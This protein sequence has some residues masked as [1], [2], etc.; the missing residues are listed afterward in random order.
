[1][2]RCPCCQG[3]TPQQLLLSTLFSHPCFHVPTPKCTKHLCTCVSIFQ[4]IFKGAVSSLGSKC[5]CNELELLVTFDN[6]N[7]HDFPLFIVRLSIL[8]PITL[9]NASRLA[10]QNGPIKYTFAL[11]PFCFSLFFQ[12]GALDQHLFGYLHHLSAI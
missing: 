9:F 3:P 7:C 12:V 8:N 11:S 1:M 6:H 4:S 2:V 5:T 10:K